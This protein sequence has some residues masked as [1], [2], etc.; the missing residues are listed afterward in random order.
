MMLVG[1]TLG[2]AKIPVPF[3]EVGILTS[4]IVLGLLVAFAVELPLAFGAAIVGVFALFHGYAH[5]HEAGDTVNGVEYM[6]GFTLATAG[7]HAVGIGFAQAMG[8]IAMKPLIRI[9]GALCLP[10]GIALLLGLL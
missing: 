9:A 2:M 1:A 8:F 6:A 3:V 10:V 7:L 5:G 4:V